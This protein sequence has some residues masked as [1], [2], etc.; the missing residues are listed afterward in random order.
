MTPQIKSQ[1]IPKKQTGPVT[2]VVGKTFDKIVLDPK[3]DA[4][5]EFYAHYCDV[6]KK[7]VPVYNKLAKKFKGNSN[8]VVAK[9][10]A[11][12][13]DVPSEYDAPP[14]KGYPAIY[15]APAD[16]KMAPIKYEGDQDFNGLVKFVEK[17]ATVL[18][19]KKKEEL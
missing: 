7:F 2:V 3:K 6:S 11:V 10:D 17:H 14:E 12:L 18:L 8:L 16:K 9:M 1:P 13:N 5:I 19:K 4:L 15:F